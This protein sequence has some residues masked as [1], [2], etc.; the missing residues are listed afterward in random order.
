MKKFFIPFALVLF[1]SGISLAQSKAEEDAKIKALLLREV[2][3]L[4]KTQDL[5]EY[6][7]CFA[8]SEEIV[9]GPNKDQLIIGI[10]VLRP[11][12]EQIITNYKKNPNANTWEFSDW[13]IRINGKSAFVTCVQ[14][15]TTPSGSQVHVFKSDYL[16][17][18]NGD[19]KIL[20][21]R[22]YHTAP[23]KN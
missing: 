10:S 18:Y 22:F 9:F 20:D 17:K 12:A 21:H 4:N 1:F 16:E 23:S 13:K 8:P 19:W 2:D 6:M 5:E 14:T 7:A 11:F 3:A 15:T